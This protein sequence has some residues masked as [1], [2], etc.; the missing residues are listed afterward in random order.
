MT[1]FD[2]IFGAGLFFSLLVGFFRGFL[3]EFLG[4]AAWILAHSITMFFLKES[5][6]FLT[7][8]LPA[9]VAALGGPLLVFFFL[10]TLFMVLVRYINNNVSFDVF[11]PFNTLLGVCF[12][13]GRM[14]LLTVLCYGALFHYVPLEEYPKNFLQSY[15]VKPIVY[16]LDKTEKQWYSLGRYFFEDVFQDS[17][18]QKLYKVNK[19]K[20]FHHY[21]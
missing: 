10:L 4:L 11:V 6:T 1:V 17:Q 15:H 9:N 20:Y 8:W 2:W 3:R 5:K 19:E 13:F 14:I 16:L 18:H 7:P 21:G 12:G